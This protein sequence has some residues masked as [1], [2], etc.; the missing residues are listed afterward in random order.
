MLS[1]GWVVFWKALI[2]AAWASY[3][4]E[5]DRRKARRLPPIS[6]A[7]LV[8]FEKEWQRRRAKQPLLLVH[9]F[10]DPAESVGPV[11]E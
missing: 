2:L 3:T 1:I 9:R 8:A 11:D 5:R 7:M 10:T 6:K 4:E